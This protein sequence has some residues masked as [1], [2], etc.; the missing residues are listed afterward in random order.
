[1]DLQNILEDIEKLSLTMFRKG[2]FGVFHGSISTKIGINKFLIN[3]KNAVFDKLTRNDMI[4]LYDKKDYRWN[5][6][7]IDSDIHLNIY[8]NFFDAK[9]IAFAMPPNTVSYSLSHDFIIPKDYFGY[10]KF[11]KIKI[12]DPKNFDDWYERAP[13]EICKNL[14]NSKTNFLIIRGYGVVI[15]ARTFSNLAKDI[16]LIDNSCKILQ[17]NQIYK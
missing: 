17:L 3:K 7:S 4:L 14:L 2:F 16:A 8:K 13:S 6:A 15:Y 5:E 12:Y 9:F 10:E 1:M 11:K